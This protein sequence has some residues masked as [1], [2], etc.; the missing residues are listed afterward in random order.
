MWLQ[1]LD[2]I[3]TVKLF[4]RA[5][6]TGN[7]H[8]HLIAVEKMLNLF[9]A[10]G[11]IHYA[12]SARLYLQLMNELHQKYPWLYEK[13]INEGYHTIR[14]SKRHWAGLWSD[15][16]IEQVMMK[17]LKSRGGLTRGRGMT[18]SV[19]HQWVHSMH[20]CA[21]VHNAM[22]VLTGLG[23][24]T[25]EQHIELS[26]SRCKRDYDDMAKLSVW[27]CQ[28]EPFDENVPGLRSLSTGIM[29]TD[30]DQVNCD[31]AEKIDLNIHQKLDNI[32]VA[33]G[34]IKRNDRIQTLASLYNKVGKK[35]KEINVNPVNLFTRLIAV[36]QRDKDI[37]TYFKYELTAEPTSLFK[38]GL[39]RKPDK[40]QLRGALVDVTA[41]V[42]EPSGEYVLDGGALI[43]KVRWVKGESYRKTALNYAE[44]VRKKYGEC[45]IIFDGY[46]TSAT[47]KGHEHQRRSTGK[48]SADITIAEENRTHSDQEAFL[49]N[50]RNKDQ[51]V[52][53]LTKYLRQ[54]GNTVVNCLKDADTQIA[55][56]ATDLASQRRPVTVVADDTDVILLLIHHMEE[57]ME[58]IYFSSEKSKKI[59]SIRQVIKKVGP[60]VKDHLLL[61]HAWT[62]CDTTSAIFGLGKKDLMKKLQASEEI[63][64]L[65]DVICD[66]WAEQ[67]NVAHAGQRLSVI[68]Y[69][70]KVDDTLNTLR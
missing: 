21:S 68:M 1:Y 23:T 46:S 17:S 22:N 15:L 56:Q 8:L 20:R 3:D 38:E 28:H 58:D 47:T 51:L 59:W 6:R 49:A 13:F 55:S 61:L 27:F 65:S 70:G 64:Q 53:L 45:Y 39:M 43:H 12:K 4:I 10:T 52:T 57:H 16:V 34:K 60:I 66:P 37:S 24:K 67:D 36:A 62:G 32:I 41:E 63:Q 25:N 33:D 11:H 44:Y 69:G 30:E 9:A 31:L 14:R 7:W 18:D 26:S 29:A 50:D 40:P 54:S 35:H 2:Y 5:E 42:S 19:R 48:T